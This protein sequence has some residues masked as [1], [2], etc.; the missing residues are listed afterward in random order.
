MHTS[1]EH[2]DEFSHRYSCV[3]LMSKYRTV[4]EPQ[5]FVLLKRPSG[6]SVG[7]AVQGGERSNREASERRMPSSGLGLA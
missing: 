3:A 5:E 2:L 7:N 4:L 1:W 6:C